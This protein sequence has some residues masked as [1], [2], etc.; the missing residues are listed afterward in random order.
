MSDPNDNKN[1]NDSLSKET[2]TEHKSPRW[3]QEQREKIERLK[4]EKCP[5]CHEITL[6][7]L[8]WK[9]CP[10]KVCVPCIYQIVKSFVPHGELIFMG[11]TL[12]AKLSYIK[13]TIKCP[14]CRENQRSDIRRVNESQLISWL[15]VPNS[16][17]K[18][19]MSQ[20]IQDISFD[21]KFKNKIHLKYRC[22]K[23]SL[24]F[25]NQNTCLSH[26][27]RCTEST[28]YCPLCHMV[29]LPTLE[30]KDIDT[31]IL[32]HLKTECQC[33]I[34][35]YHCPEKVPILLMSDHRKL[36][37]E[38]LLIGEYL[39]DEKRKF[40][41]T[42][43]VPAC[44]RGDKWEDMKNR[45]SRTLS[46]KTDILETQ[47]III[48]DLDEQ[49]IETKS[50]TLPIVNEFPPTN[51]DAPEDDE[52]DVETLWEEYDPNDFMDVDLAML[53]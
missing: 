28:I 46:Q 5:V 32:N 24:K 7:M 1:D 8:C 36:H 33:K 4:N 18:L 30:E 45:I 44:F 40:T 48:P 25:T 23:C 3:T 27:S 10:H 22:V 38:L 52:E 19:A 42:Q 50:G 51:E 14:V 47:R 29:L 6:H 43:D 11:T 9:K 41:S 35:C 15:D 53:Q 2:K 13:K 39:T 26:I 16:D 20:R 31:R 17:W 21:L 49:E 34:L 37:A 12:T